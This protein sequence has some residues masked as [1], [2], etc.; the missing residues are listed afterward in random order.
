MYCVGT[1]DG[2]RFFPETTTAMLS[3][4]IPFHQ[5]ESHGPHQSFLG[6]VK[7]LAR[8]LGRELLEKVL[9]L[10]YAAQNPSTPPQARAVIYAALI[11]FLTPLDA[12]PDLL[13]AIGYGDDLG[14]VTLALVAIASH[15]DQNVKDRAHATLETWFAD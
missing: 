9:W 4:P 6:Q 2:D 14:A 5:P 7:G 10:Y 3:D 1:Y 12:V 11:Y 15:I 13:P 8:T